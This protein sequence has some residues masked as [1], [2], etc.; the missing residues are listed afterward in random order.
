MK[1]RLSS[2]QH[3][4]YPRASEMGLQLNLE[5]TFTEATDLGYLPTLLSSQNPL[6]GISP[7]YKTLEFFFKRNISNK[8]AATF[9]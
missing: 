8:I 5:K 4:L 9:T 1:S 2:A 6:P 7:G 3:S